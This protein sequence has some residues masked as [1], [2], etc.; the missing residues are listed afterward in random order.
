MAVIHFR[1]ASINS[2]AFFKK[3]GTKSLYLFDEQYSLCHR[4][5]VTPENTLLPKDVSCEDCIKIMKCDH[6][7]CMMFSPGHVYCRKCD[8]IIY[9]ED[10]RAFLS[11]KNIEY[12][13]SNSDNEKEKEDLI[14]NNFKP[15]IWL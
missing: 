15:F 12:Y 2:Y 11:G 5:V 6:E 10:V 9:V 14:F 1:S 13:M 8:I 7:F 4:A 3:R